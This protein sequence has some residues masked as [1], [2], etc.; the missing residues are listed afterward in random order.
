M[1]VVPLLVLLACG[2]PAVDP[3][4]DPA[5][6]PLVA[7][8]PP[9]PALDVG[10]LVEGSPITLSVSGV[11]RG[12]TVYYFFGQN[13]GVGPCHPTLPGL[14]LGLLQPTMLGQATANAAGVA[15]RTLTV[16]DPLSVA[17]ARFQARAV[18]GRTGA[19]SAIV[20]AFGLTHWNSA[21]LIKVIGLPPAV[22]APCSG[23][24][25]VAIFQASHRR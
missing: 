23:G 5:T 13:A 3:A 16:P 22:A 25:A 17:T 20:H 10:P 1:R 18:S 9:S 12:A 7:Q 11:P 6:A 2:M 15:S 19:V 4:A 8:A 24:R 14:C 21:A